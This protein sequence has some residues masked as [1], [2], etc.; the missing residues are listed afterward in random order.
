[1]FS[2]A[3]FDDF[4]EN[5]YSQAGSVTLTDEAGRSLECYIERSLFVQE[6]EYLLLLPVDAAIEIF[7]WQS[8]GDE[9]EAIPVDDDATIDRIFD[10]ATAVLAEQNLLLKRTAFALT[11]AGDLPPVEDAELF[12][13]EIEDETGDLEPERL[14]LLSSFYYEDQEYSIYTPLD[15][16]LF[17]AR[18]N[19]SGQPELL[20]PEEFQKLQPLLAEQLFDELEE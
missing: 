3:S 5:E 12:T 10:V 6:Q 9:E 16:L 8:Q 15:P 1:M 17:F 2:S 19:S 11:V 4:E 14:Q 13:L 18:L 20:S 7:V